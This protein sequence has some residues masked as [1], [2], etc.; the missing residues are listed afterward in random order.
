MAI[1]LLD[2]SVA[3]LFLP[4]RTRRQERALYEPHMIGNTLALCFQSVAE[5]WKLAERHDWGR[6]R[7]D[8]LEA[9]LRLFLVIPYDYE[10]ARFGRVFRSKQSAPDGVWR[11]TTHGLL[12][13]RCIGESSFSRMIATSKTFLLLA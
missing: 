3:S 8:D 2:T 10:L 12:Q 13:P 4:H 5:I 7:R 6:P 11:A 9:F 1:I